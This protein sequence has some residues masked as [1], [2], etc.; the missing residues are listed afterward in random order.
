MQKCWL[1]PAECKQQ[2]TTQEELFSFTKTLEVKV[3]KLEE[4]SKLERVLMYT[5][6]QVRAHYYSNG[7]AKHPLFKIILTKNIKR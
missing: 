2:T 5:F 1:P 7:Y 4:L 3:F 6:I